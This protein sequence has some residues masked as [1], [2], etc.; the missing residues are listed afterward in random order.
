MID[1][2]F[3]Y[4]LLLVLLIIL[5]FVIILY[6][7]GHRRI[8]APPLMDVNYGVSTPTNTITTEWQNLSLIKNDGISI[9]ETPFEFIP[10][11]GD[12]N[13][14]F[15]GKMFMYAHSLGTSIWFS[16]RL[17]DSGDNDKVV[18]EETDFVLYPENEFGLQTLSLIFNAEETDNTHNFVLQAKSRTTTPSFASDNML[19]NSSYF[20]YI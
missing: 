12:R 20:V 15:N 14:S 11:S 13:R 9:P 1:I 3:F 16:L 19:I 18:A 2:G 5:L 17:L 4:L 8:I 7:G 6:S 10:L